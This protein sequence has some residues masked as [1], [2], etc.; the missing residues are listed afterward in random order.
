MPMKRR[1]FILPMLSAG[2]A[3]TLRSTKDSRAAT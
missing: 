1:H 3:G 2:L